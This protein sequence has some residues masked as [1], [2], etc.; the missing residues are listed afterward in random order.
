MLES[1]QVNNKDFGARI[2][3]CTLGGDLMRLTLGTVPFLIFLKHF[4]LFKC[5]QAVVQSDFLRCFR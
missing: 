3:F 5:L 4:L 2:D 1:L